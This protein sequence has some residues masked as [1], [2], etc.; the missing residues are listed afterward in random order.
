[1]AK[2]FHNP[3]PNYRKICKLGIHVGERFKMNIPLIQNCPP[4]VNIYTYRLELGKTLSLTGE[5]LEDLSGE[6]RVQAS[7]L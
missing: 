2:V 6:C 1:M 4:V 7:L 5:L 3:Q